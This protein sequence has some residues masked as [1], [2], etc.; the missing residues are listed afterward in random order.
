MLKDLSVR[1]PTKRCIVI[2]PEMP[3]KAMLWF[4]GMLSQVEYAEECAH[5]TYCATN[6]S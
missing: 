2:V 5:K 1:G 6:E 3:P 4:L